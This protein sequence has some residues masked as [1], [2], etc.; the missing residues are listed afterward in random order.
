MEWK[1]RRKNC[2]Q[3]NEQNMG[4][5]VLWLVAFRGKSSPNCTRARKLSYLIKS[6][7]IECNWPRLLSAGS[8]PSNRMKGRDN[9]GFGYKERGSSPLL[10]LLVRQTNIF[11]VIV[12]MLNKLRALDKKRASLV[13][14]FF[15]ARKCAFFMIERAHIFQSKS[16]YV[17]CVR[18]CVCV[19]STAHLTYTVRGTWWLNW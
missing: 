12:A 3:E 13:S 9:C 5:A 6:N 14:A 15:V 10:T 4:S 1:H 17:T 11:Y 2:T 8:G 16:S 18:V 19:C 7:R